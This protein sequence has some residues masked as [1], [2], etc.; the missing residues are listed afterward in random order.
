MKWCKFF[1]VHSGELLLF[2]C[3]GFFTILRSTP[4]NN[5]TL[6]LSRYS[7]VRLTQ[8]KE[9]ESIATQIGMDRHMDVPIIVA[10]HSPLHRRGT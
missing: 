8:W 10:V 4:N 5:P 2:Y 3:V 1:S 6:T 7:S 9:Q